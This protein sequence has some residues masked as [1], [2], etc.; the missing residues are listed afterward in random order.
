MTKDQRR[1]RAVRKVFYDSQTKHWFRGGR[2]NFDRIQ[3]D[4]DALDHE[5][6]FHYLGAEVV[7]KNSYAWEVRCFCGYGRASFNP[8]NLR[9]SCSKAYGCAL[10]GVDVVRLVVRWIERGGP[11]TLSRKVS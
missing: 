1:W 8:N 5:R 9:Y 2:I 7:E 4:P 3:T 10:R 6:L 11:K